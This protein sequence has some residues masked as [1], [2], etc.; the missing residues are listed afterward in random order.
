MKFGARI[1]TTM[2]IGLLLAPV[3]FADTTKKPARHS[4]K[5]SSA[6]A[7]AGSAAPADPQPLGKLNLFAA[8]PPQARAGRGMGMH[9]GNRDD[10]G[11]GIPRVELFMG[12]TYW[13]AMPKGPRNRI[14]GMH[15]GTTSLTFNVKSHLGVVF[16]FGGFRVNSLQ[17]TNPGPGFTPSRV[18]DAS[19]NVFTILAGPRISFRRRER[20]SPFVQV[21]A[22]LAHA[23]EVTLSGCDFPIY[24]CTPLLRERTFIMTA[25]GGLDYRYNHRFAIRLI[26][27]E[28]LLTKF[29]DDPTL[30]YGPTAFQRNLRL[31]SGII[32]RFGGDHSMPP[33][34]PSAMMSCVMDKSS[35][36]ANSGDVVAVESST[37]EI[38]T[39]P[40]T[41]SWSSNA[42]T[43]EGT[44]PAVRWNTAGATPGVY[45]IKGRVD[46]GRGRSADCSANIRVEAALNRAPTMSCSANHNSVVIGEPVQITADA[47]DPDNDPLTY[48]WTSS[49]GQIRGAESSAKFETANLRAGRYSII[50]HVL[51]GR[52][53]EADCTLAVNVQDPPPPPEMVELESRLALH[54]IYFQTARPTT[55][56]PAAGLV[57]S[58]ERILA[59]LAT[60]FKRYLTF[61]PEAHL[62][63]GGHADE[64]GS[65]EFNKALTERRVERSRNYLIQHGVAPLAIETRSFGKKENLSESQIKEQIEDNP[66]L[67]PEDRQEM[68]SN[69]P[70]MVLANNRRVDIALSTT[71]QQ[72]TRRY[73]FN[74]RDYL[75]LISTH[76]GEKTHAMTKKTVHIAKLK[77]KVQ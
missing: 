66:D 41:Y 50:G 29:H 43:V 18:V 33:A 26:Q 14:D 7:T 67:T 77:H 27:A 25:G 72:S 31:T 45:T 30:W 56:N 11:N 9:Y 16:E 35:V 54:S 58:Q 57:D 32:F 53:G 6:R 10:S 21:L 47:R 22:G 20:L 49:G 70:V 38:G 63:L 15:G 4:T 36:Y 40:V 61:R 65:E 24:A 1:F 69:L 64:R 5:N 46:N 39:G 68:T 28:F 8:L 23:D 34:T 12:Y 37:S 51:D 71:K 42:G 60:D 73:P 3:L 48:S 75:A 62:I 44:G 76:G 13:A 74:A 59:T 19:G 17:F 2:A 52:G 55:A